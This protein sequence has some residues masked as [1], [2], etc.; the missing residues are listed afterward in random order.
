LTSR[1]GEEKLIK[2][3]PAGIDTKIYGR[4]ELLAR[5]QSEAEAIASF[6]MA[7]DKGTHEGNSSNSSSIYPVSKHVVM[8]FV[9]YPN[10]GKSSTINALVGGRRLESPRPLGRR[11]TSRR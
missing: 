5:L 1:W 10:V 4:D 3:A 8:G 11:S 9:G 6:R 2:E 7:S